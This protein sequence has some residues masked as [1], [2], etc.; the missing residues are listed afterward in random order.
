MIQFY[1]GWRDGVR[2]EPEPSSGKQV[3]KVNPVKSTT[4]DSKYSSASF[5][6]TAI[7]LVL[8][9][10]FPSIFD[11]CFFISVRTAS[12]LVISGFRIV[13]DGKGY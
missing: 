4:S 7:F 5:A 13:G 1:T 10:A 2:Q 9:D 6:N 12:A 8:S 3:K 11:R